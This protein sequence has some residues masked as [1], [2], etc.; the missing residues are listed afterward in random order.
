MT[1][2]IKVV[3]LIA[4]HIRYNKQFEYLTRAIN[5]IKNQIYPCDLLISLSFEE[6]YSSLFKVGITESEW[7]KIITNNQRLYQMEH[8][9]KLF[10]LCEKYD[11]I[12]FLDD[13]D[14]YEY[15][16]VEQFVNAYKQRP[17]SKCQIR[18][19]YSGKEI[20]KGQFKYDNDG[21]LHQGKAEFWSCGITYECFKYF[22][23]L[24]G[25]QIECLRNVYGDMLF[26]QFLYGNQVYKDY[27]VIQLSH[28]LY[29][30]NIHSDSVCSMVKKENN[31]QQNGYL[32]LVMGV[33]ADYIKLVKN[34][35]KRIPNDSNITKL[36][37]KLCS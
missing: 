9:H 30:Y 7:C 3:V 20:K 10:P 12:M 32:Y 34:G 13:D 14:T 37:K 29:N 5:S 1:E 6:K 23:D 26:R 31:V 35:M 27:L 28:K 2:E 36:A 19:G 4:S 33:L 15:N 21:I 25:D 24:V 22:W 16:R 8:L 18:E 11:L 17:H